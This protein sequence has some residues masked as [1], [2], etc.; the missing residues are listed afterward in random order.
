MSDIQGRSQDEDDDLLF[1]DEDAPDPSSATSGPI[2]APWKLLIVDD[3]PEVHAITRVVLNDVTFDGRRLQ[4][5]SAHS[6]G[7]ARAILKDHPDIAA[8]LLDVVM[9]TEDAGLRLV[10]HIREGL[11]NRRVRII[12]RTGQPGQAPERQVIVSYDINDYKAKSELTAQKLF[13]TTVAA[14]RSYQHID[15]IER[16]RQG[17]EAI[18]DAAGT[19]FEQRCMDRFAVG[20]VERVAALLPRAAGAFLCAVPDGRFREAVVL[21]GTGVFAEATGRPVGAVLPDAA[22]ADIAAA[23]ARGRS[24]HRDD[25]SVA[26]FQTQSPGPGALF[27]AGHGGLPEVERRLV[28]IFCSRMSVGFDNVSLYEQLRLAQIATVHA[29]GKLAEYKD[30]V[31]GEHVRRIGRWATAIARELQAQGSV[32]GDAD[33]RFCELIGLASML[34]DVGK[35]AIPDQIL[36]KPGKLDPE[37]IIQMREHA[38]I[39]GRILRDASGPVGGRSYLSMGAEIAESH[40]EKF[41]GTGYPHGLAGDAIPLSGRIVAVAD[42]YDALLH[43]RPYKEAWELAAVVDLIRAESG[44]HF[45]PR[46]VDAFVA[47]LERG[48]PEA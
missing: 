5:L 25:H 19:L 11:G 14:L 38:A 3:D 37:E 16:N 2:A 29:L 47:V 22:C 7:E 27:I 9:E 4:F 1:A 43:R 17:L 40:H 18:V 28:E 30:E 24:L 36:R 21:C 34:H 45:D 35:V 26:L 31:T 46:V 8:V 15:A 41:D 44:R 12:L 39:G 42:V 32:G 6:G 48:G 13:T 10:H 33:D 20:V 23:L